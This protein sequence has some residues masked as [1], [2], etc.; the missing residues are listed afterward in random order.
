MATGFLNCISPLIHYHIKAPIAAVFGAF[1]LLFINKYL[2]TE[3]NNSITLT[4]RYTMFEQ[5]YFD[6]AKER[7]EALANHNIALWYKIYEEEQR[8]NE[9]YF[10]IMMQDDYEQCRKAFD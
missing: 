3:I 10:N 7:R 4:R 8:R 9:Y 5:K 6:H 2:N 1:S